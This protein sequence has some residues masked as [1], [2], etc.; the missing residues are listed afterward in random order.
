MELNRAQLLIHDDAALAQFCVDHNIPN[1]VLIERLGPNRDA[2][3]V[4]GDG[5]H[6]LV[7]TWLIH[8]DRLKILL[9]PL[10]KEIMALCCLTLM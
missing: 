3:L 5:N 1:N 9:S 6:I 8:Q 2:N 7:R 10:M 4:E